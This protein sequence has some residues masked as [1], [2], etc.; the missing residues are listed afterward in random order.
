MP[1]EFL[2]IGGSLVE[3]DLV[4]GE[5]AG[6][7]ES[8]M[9]LGRRADLVDRYL[10]MGSRAETLLPSLVSST[11][12]EEPEPDRGVYAV[13]LDD[14]PSSLLLRPEDLLTSLDFDRPYT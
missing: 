3:Y 2:L 13:R 8:L 5:T 6:T 14:P 11:R 10:L 7:A 12:R 9:T 4:T 1:P